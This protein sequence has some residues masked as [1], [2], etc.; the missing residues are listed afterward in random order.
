MIYGCHNHGGDYEQGR[1]VI[2]C[3]GESIL[4]W[5]DL[6][7]SSQVC[8]VQKWSYY[9]R[10]IDWHSTSALWSS[11]NGQIGWILRDCAKRS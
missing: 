10:C 1:G 11:C 8:T 6:G 7:V 9:D 4:E 5:R 3:I 2:N